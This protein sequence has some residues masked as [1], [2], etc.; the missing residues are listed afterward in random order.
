M[1]DMRTIVITGATD[2]LGKGLA[3]E[4][5]SSGAR[6]ILHGRNEEKG[7]A[8]LEELRQHKTG[9]AGA[10]PHVDGELEWLRA[11]FASLDDV[12]ELADTLSGEERIDVLVNNAGIGTA[13]PREESQ[14]GYELTFQVNYLAPFLLTR[15]L[16]P[17]IERSAPS[18]IVNVS[19]AGQMPIDFD[20]VMLERNY[21]GVQAYC[22]SKL[23]LVMFTFDL[24]EELEGSG[25]TANC[26]HPGTYMPT[27]M[28]RAAGV[29]PV[30]PLEDGIAATMRLITSPEVE[31][32]NGHYFDGTSESAPHQQ[33]EDP[34]ARQRLRELS[35]ELTGIQAAA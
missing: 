13:G 3:T 18:R 2:G 16:L 32:V 23:A 4:L 24:A 5:A 31:G 34:E 22:Q 15:R 28:V 27:N 33:A 7:Q 14:D 1:E 17:L 19:S 21:S 35:A 20:D 6:L 30:T 12:R 9:R 8:L 10:R 29:E 25:V 26:L 11:D